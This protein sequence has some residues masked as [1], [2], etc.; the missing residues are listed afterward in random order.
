MA[1]LTF[2]TTAGQTIARELMIAYLNTGTRATPVWSAVGKRVEDSSMEIDWS[3]ETKND[4]LGQTYI[5]LKKPTITQTFDPVEL[6]S[7]DSAAVAIWNKAIRDQ[8]YAA[9]AAMDMLIVHFYAGASATP[10]AERYYACAVRPSGLGGEGGGTVNMPFDVTYGGERVIGTASKSGSVVT[11]TP[12][13]TPSFP[14]L[15]ALTISDATL[16]PTFS[17]GIT[18]YTADASS[19]SSTITVT[20]TTV[21]STLAILVNGNSISSGDSVSWNEGAN[22]VSITV[23]YNGVA[24]NYEV[25]VT[26]QS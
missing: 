8:D 16:V 24:N 2:N 26:Y 23:T 21:G 4:I 15:S 13:S 1:D 10:F 20:A 19:A 7:G 25:Y 18:S 22:L 12:A 17:A 14:T 9:L 6:D 5:T 11:F 3:D